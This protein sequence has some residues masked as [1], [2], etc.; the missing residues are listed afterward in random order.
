M[1]PVPRRDWTPPS[2]RRVRALRDRLRLVYGRPIA[3][4][5]RRPLEELILTVLSQSTSRPQPRRRL[6]APRRALPGLGGGARRAQRRGRGRDP[7]RRHLQ[8][9]VGPDPGDPARAAGPALARPPRAACRSRRRATSCARC[10]A[11]AARR[12]RACSSSPSACATSPSTRTSRASARGSACSGPGAPFE[13]LH[14]DDA[15][16]HAA[17]P[18][19]RVPRQPAA[20][21]PAD[22]PRPAAEVPRVRAAADVPVCN[23]AE[24][25]SRRLSPVQR[26]CEAKPII[27]YLELTDPAGIRPARGGAPIERVDPP[28]GAREPR[29][30]RGHRRATT[31]GRTTR[32]RPTPGGRRT[33]RRWRP[34]CIGPARATPSCARWATTSRSPTSASCPRI[35]GNGLGRRAAR[36]RAPARLRARLPG[37]GPHLLARRPARARQLPGARPRRLSR[38]TP[39]VRASAR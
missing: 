10:P 23:V 2:R 21:R 16:P 25:R 15:R 30:L 13:E 5:H 37:L 22:V 8:G 7:P 38:R 17:R 35:H 14:D 20:P 12:R 3:P 36:A 9:Q 28:D 1:P 32:T 6:P 19:A 26:R 33:P 31:P 29:L 18:G 11:W 39:D 27:S 24:H 34:G 4:P